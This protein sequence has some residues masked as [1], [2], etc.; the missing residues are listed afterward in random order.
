[1]LV[2]QTC[3]SGKCLKELVCSGHFLRSVGTEVS[4][5]G[6]FIENLC[7]GIRVSLR[8]SSSDFDSGVMCCFWA[9]MLKFHFELLC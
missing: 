2:G 6:G 8:T 1:M 3:L 9:T 4:L 5:N 7:V